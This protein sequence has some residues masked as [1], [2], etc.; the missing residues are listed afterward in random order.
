[1]SYFMSE[2]ARQYL[3]L[4][5]SV[6]AI[7]LAV[8]GALVFAS[9]QDQVDLPLARHAEGQTITSLSSPAVDVT[10]DREF[11]YEG[12]LRVTLSGTADAE[13]H[14]FA[15]HGPDGVARAFYW[16]Q[17]EHF[18]PNNSRTY[19][20]GSTTT[21]DVG[22][23]TFYYDT[24]GYADFQGIQSS[25]PG[26]DGA[27]AVSILTRRHH[28]FPQRVARV[29]MFHF[30]GVDRR[31][32]LMIIYGEALDAPAGVP[33]GRPRFPLDAQSAAALVERMRHGLTIRNR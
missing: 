23:L 26:S 17:F 28:T 10:L 8:A 1:M 31:S 21:I 5:V 29:R 2:R 16:L 12:A 7:A 19:D 14:L 22:G 15:K 32:E 20:V 25:Q 30:P 13:L 9:G 11:A 4:S 18:L 27:A 33:E 3:S 24:L 6:G